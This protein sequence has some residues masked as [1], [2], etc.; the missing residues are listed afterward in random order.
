MTEGTKTATSHYRT[1]LLSATALAL[2]SSLPARAQQI[3]A[4]EAAA[5]ETILVTGTRRETTLLD[6]PINISAVSAEKLEQQRIFDLR[7]LSSFVNGITIIDTG[8]RSTGTIVVRGLGAGDSGIGGANAD[9]AVSTY[10]GEVPLYLDF[11]LI[12]IQRVEVLL[13]P[14]GTLYGSGTLAGAIRYI[15]NRPNADE[16]SGT[17][18]MKVSATENS[19]DLGFTGHGTINM[20]IVPGKIALRSTFGY[21]FE[22]G[23]IDYNYVLKEPG[24]SLPQPGVESLGNDQQRFANFVRHPDVN[25]E[26]TFTTRHSLLLQPG[27]DLRFILTYAY[28]KTETDGFQA[29]SAGVMGTGKYENAARYLE[30]RTRDAHLI[31]LEVNANLGDFAELVSATGITRQKMVGVTDN[32]DL[33]LDLDYDYEL[34]PGFSSYAPGTQRY[35]QFNQELRLVS[36]H[37]GPISWTIG[38]FYNEFEF[39]SRRDEYVPG[40]AAWAGITYRPDDLEYISFVNTK[41]T[42]KAVFGEATWQ[43]TDGWQVTGGLRYFKYDAFAEGGSDLPLLSGGRRRTPYPLIQFD[44]SRIRQGDTSDSGTVYKLNTSYKI[45]E[46]LLIYG[47]YSTG[48]RIGGV[49]RVVPC[50]IPLP[51]GQ[52][53]CALPDELAYGPDETTNKEIGIKFALFDKR[54]TGALS[55][56]HIDWSG[57]QIASQTINGAIGI[58]R[59]ASSATSKGVEFE[60]MAEPFDGFT[61]QGNYAY[62]DATLKDLAPGIVVTRGGGLV[63]GEPGDRLPGSAK[64]QGSLGATWTLPVMETD[65]LRLNWTATYRGDVVTRVGGRGFGET[66][67]DYTLHRASAT[68]THDRFEFGLFV[69]N[70][71]DTYAVTAVGQTTE[72]QFVND[73]VVLRYYQ[74]SVVRPRTIGFETR[75]MF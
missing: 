10:L 53:L 30:P 40:Y 32:T 51:P 39:A 8:A 67:P 34:F 46:D 7:D 50:I 26:R 43:I 3:A 61:I 20:P 48:Y 42:E 52:N 38:G 57:I 66:M 18:Y 14:Q 12:D 60:F 74:K 75:M 11:K 63:D 62:N 37:G 72:Q 55:G 49:N 35:E 56:Y 15:P 47:T 19:G 36:K 24:V 9:T 54:F 73:G 64:H 45:N 31:A 69:N 41:T 59:N 17:A 65:A 25:F 22:P 29:N 21:F 23:F 58:I 27:D 4:G 1:L 13:G 28:Q 6:A 2:A 70:I 71:F 16:V 5:E 68:Y 33:L 44:P